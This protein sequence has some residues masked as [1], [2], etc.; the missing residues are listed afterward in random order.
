VSGAVHAHA[1]VV[2][3]AAHWAPGPHTLPHV[4]Q[5]AFVSFDVQEP[6]HTIWPEGQA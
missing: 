4:P 6:L 3:L 2:P 5:L 1:K